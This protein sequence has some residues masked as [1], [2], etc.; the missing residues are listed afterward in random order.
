MRSRK[1][2]LDDAAVARRANRPQAR[3]EPP[4]PV[5][6]E[7]PVA[8]PLDPAASMPHHTPLITTIVAA[9]A[10]AWAFGA[11]AH[12]LKLS[13]LVGYLLAG[14]VIGPFTPGFVADQSARRRSSR[15]SASFC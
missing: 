3:T 7:M 2:M 9:L 13:P 12:R 1:S 8:H 4:P 15:R 11:I 5:L 6:G 14:I 10:L